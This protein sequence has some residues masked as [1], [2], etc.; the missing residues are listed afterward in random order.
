LLVSLAACSPAPAGPL[1]KVSVAV[2]SGRPDPVFTLTPEQADA[3]RACRKT[4]T[5]KETGTLPEGLGFRFFAIT[6]FEAAPLLVGVDGAWLDQGGQPTPV[7]LCPEGFTILRKAAVE[8]LGSEEAA[9]IPE[10]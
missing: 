10:A 1:P 2:F 7:A 5:A 9:S 4:G 8:A 3:L 6:G